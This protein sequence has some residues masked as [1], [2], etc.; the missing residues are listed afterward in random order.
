MPKK[1]LVPKTPKKPF[2]ERHPKLTRRLKRAGVVAG[3]SIVGTAAV[4]GGSLVLRQGAHNIERYSRHM[5]ALDNK[6]EAE[7]A[8]IQRGIEADKFIR[9][10]SK[11][12]AEAR[13]AWIEKRANKIYDALYAERFPGF[14]AESEHYMGGVTKEGLND[15]KE[16]CRRDAW[17]RANIEIEKMQRKGG[18]PDAKSAVS[19]GGK[20][21]HPALRTGGKAATTATISTKGTVKRQPFRP[22]K[23]PSKRNR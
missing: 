17:V 7:A 22:D 8:A 2:S 19:P 23:R 10:Q 14:K 3:A 18:Q 13:K 4:V 16:E 6:R 11:I 9:V 5:I 12:N 15:F 1:P 21:M 20:G